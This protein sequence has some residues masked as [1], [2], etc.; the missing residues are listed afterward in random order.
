MASPDNKPDTLSPDTRWLMRLC[1]AQVFIML[2]FINY[3]AVLPLLKQEWGMNNTMAGS[4][5]SVYQLGYI[6]SGVLLSAL[7]DRFNTR[8]IFLTA[9]L[10]SGISNLLFALY[11]DDYLSGM[12][13]RALT[14]IG[15]GGTYMPGLKLVAER[16][17][18]EKRGKA[19]G[20]YVGSLVLG[21]SMSLAVTGAVTSFAGWRIAF[22]VCSAGVFAGLLLAKKVFEGYTPLVFTEKTLGFRTEVIKNRPALLMILGYGSHMWEMYGMRSWVAPF[23]AASLVAHGLAADKATGL[24]ATA[25]AIIV[26]VGA[27]STA[28]TGTLSDRWGR[29]RTISVVMCASACC[30]FSFGWFFH[31]NPWLTTAA[32]ILYGYLVVAESPVFSTGLTEL[33]APAYLGAAMGLQSLI[34][35]SM[36]MISPTVFGWA[37][38]LFK[39][40]S[41]W[42]G[43]AGEWGIA[44]AT[45]G[46][47]GLM[48]PVFMWLLKR[49]PESGR[50]AGGRR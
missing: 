46:I 34:G 11:A 22:A 1:I 49:S 9:A 7:T 30:S 40:W 31:V 45:C 39:G 47:G 25:A 19:V 48:G 3:S 23:F 8:Y 10:W 35:Y 44:F 13:L 37:L 16:F 29:I 27:F 15:M 43:V 21:A 50:M 20:I 2:V 41:P 26:G 38:D 33:V 18:P 24:G 6:L 17:V 12:I 5:F 36:G 14:G 4:I 42:P 28:I 32:G